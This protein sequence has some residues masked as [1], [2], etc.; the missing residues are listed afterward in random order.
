MSILERI[1]DG[2]FESVNGR[3]PLTPEYSALSKRMNVETE[4]WEKTMDADDFKQLETLFDIIAEMGKHEC[5][6]TFKVGI[7]LAAAVVSL[8]KQMDEE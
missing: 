5:F 1:F 2:E 4:H 7:A 8:Q 3:R 6:E